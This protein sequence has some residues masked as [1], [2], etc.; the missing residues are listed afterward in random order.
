MTPRAQ[1]R[2]AMLRSELL[3]LVR[4]Q[5]TDEAIESQIE[6]LL[7]EILADDPTVEPQPVVID[8]QPPDQRVVVTGIGVVSP[9]GVGLE[10]FWSGLTAGRSAIGRITFFDPSSYPCQIAGQAN[11][12]Q[13]QAF[14]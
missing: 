2:R 11:D 6:T 7:A 1:D 13:P 5:V 9:F 8:Q 10:P 3:G 12:F 14:M 4:E